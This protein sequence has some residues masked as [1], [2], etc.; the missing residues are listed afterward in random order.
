MIEQNNLTINNRRAYISILLAVFPF[1]LYVDMIFVENFNFVFGLF[2][3]SPVGP[4]FIL[5]APLFGLIGV[6]LVMRA[7]NKLKNKTL[8]KIA[9]ICCVTSMIITT[10]PSLLIFAMILN[11]SRII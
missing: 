11:Y 6:V 3:R 1:V 9:I 5:F 10:I 7:R 4:L 2:A 8:K